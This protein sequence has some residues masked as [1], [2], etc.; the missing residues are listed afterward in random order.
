[1][2]EDSWGEILSVYRTCHLE[3]SF[4]L[5]RACHITLLF[6]VKTENPPLL[7]CLLIFHFLSSVSIK[8]MLLCLCFCGVCVCVCV[9]GG[10]CLSALSASWALMRWG[11]IT[12]LLLLLIISP[13]YTRTHTHTHTHTHPHPHTNTLITHTTHHTSHT[14]TTHT[15]PH[16]HIHTT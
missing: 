7:F 3:L 2:Q 13:L 1:M 8:P 9:R 11:A 14:H 10:A 12:Y 6:Q 4:F 5:C 15:H 16:P